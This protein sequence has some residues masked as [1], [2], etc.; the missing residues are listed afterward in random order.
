MDVRTC[1][2]CG[3]VFS[4]RR[5]HARFC[6]AR[7]R[8]TWNRENSRG[9]SL[10]GG[11]AGVGSDGAA[12]T[13]G[14]AGGPL[15]WSVAAMGEVVARLGRIRPKDQVQA[16]TVLSEAVWWVTI[17]DATLVRYHPDLYD[18]ELAALPDRSAVEGALAGLRFVRNQLGYHA[19]PADFVEPTADRPATLWRWKPAACPSLNALP[20]RGQEWEAARHS[21][22]QAHLAGHPVGDTF[23][24]ANAFLTAASARILPA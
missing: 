6:S 17:V 13:D 19:D 15:G 12:G 22:Y 5:E 10:G 4:P 8:V 20:P 14:A 3:V 1:E 21:A 18:D 2:Q 23:R 11:L 24:R 9:P 7:C 16:L